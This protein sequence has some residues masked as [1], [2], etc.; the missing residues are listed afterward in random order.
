[1]L[2]PL[3]F[4]PIYKNKMWGGDKISKHLNRPEISD[5]KDIGES[6]EISSVKD[7][8]S[9]VK[10]GFLAG[11]TLNELIEIYMGDIVGEL[12]YEKFGTEFPLLIKF[13]DAA[14]NLSIQVHPDDAT[15]KERHH[16]YGKTE[17]WYVLQADKGSKLISG[18]NKNTSKQEYVELLKNNKLSEILNYEAVKSGDVFFIPAGRVHAIGAGVLLAEIQQTSDITYRIYDYDRKDKEGNMRE[19]HTDMAV[20]VIDYTLQPSYKTLYEAKSN[21]RCPLEACEYFST[22]VLKFTN[23]VKINYMEIDSFVI[24]MCTEGQLSIDYADANDTYE[25]KKGETILIPSIIEEVTL[26]PQNSL[27][28]VLEVF[29]G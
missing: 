19:L 6:W 28:E 8:L 2:Y 11:N 27:C 17:M 26:I 21:E 25:L 20:D 10:N 15:A 9:V 16:A 18:F 14:D 7:N 12:I 29:I 22:N 4:E 24:Y 1:M 5:K 3:K 23:A 13:I